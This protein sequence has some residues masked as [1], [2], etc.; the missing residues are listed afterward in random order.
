M[1]S[2]QSINVGKKMPWLWSMGMHMWLA[3]LRLRQH[4]FW[5]VAAQPKRVMVGQ[6]G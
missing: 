4:C 5:N 6:G 1:T 2:K 3:L